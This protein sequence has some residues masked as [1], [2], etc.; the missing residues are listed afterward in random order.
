MGGSGALNLAMRHPDVFGA[1]VALSPGL[2]APGGLKNSV[3]F[4]PEVIERVTA[5]NAALAELPPDQ[6]RLTFMAQVHLWMSSGHAEYP[7]AY[8]YGAAFAGNPAGPPPHIFYPYRRGPGAPLLDPA[9][10]EKYEDGFGRL[11]EKIEKYRAALAGLR[12]LVVDVGLKDGNAWLIDGCR[13]FASLAKERG[14]PVKLSEHPGGHVGRLRERLEQ[15]LF[16]EFSRHLAFG[17]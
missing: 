3:F 6:A 17:D 4:M 8:A 2:A 12:T 14:V 10:M 13:Q 16:P 7:L 11:A 15:V 9:V 1:A 5:E